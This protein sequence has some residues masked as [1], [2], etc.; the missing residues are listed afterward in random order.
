VGNPRT[1]IT[2]ATA[3]LMLFGV[4][5][6]AYAGPTELYAGHTTAGNS[7]NTGGV[8]IHATL[9]SGTSSLLGDTEGELFHTCNMGTLAGTTKH[10]TATTVDAA[11]SSLTWGST[12][13]C[14]GVTKTLAT[15]SLDITYVG[16]QNGD[17]Q[18]DGTVSG[19]GLQFT[20]LLFGTLDCVYGSGS[21]T[22]L[23]ILSGS[24]SSHA[25]LTINAPLQRQSGVGCP[26]TVKW[27]A[28]YV[29]TSPTGLNVRQ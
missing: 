11:V 9:K 28:N 26:E 17:G 23:G 3:A 4:V 13:N 6:P 22:Y 18:G 10:T 7:N 27:S 8:A 2:V 1:V 15:G 16:D 29:V 14:T 20:V 19:T 12:F 21:G 24:T 25:S 5:D